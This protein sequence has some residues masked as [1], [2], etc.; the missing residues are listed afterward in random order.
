MSP[1]F[2]WSVVPALIIWLARWLPRYLGK[3]SYI[4]VSHLSDAGKVGALRC[5]LA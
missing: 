4:S 5:L 3:L 2:W 1:S